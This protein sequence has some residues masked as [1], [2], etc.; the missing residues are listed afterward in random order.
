MK[1]TAFLLLVILVFVCLSFSPYRPSRAQHPSGEGGRQDAS[2]SQQTARLKQV[3]QVIKDLKSA[4]AVFER[5]DLFQ[6]LSKGLEDRPQIGAILEKGVVF[7]LDEFVV[8]RALSQPDEHMTLLLPDGLGGAI[9]LELTRADIFAPG[10]S[11]KTSQPT[12]EDLSDSAGIHYRGIVKGKERSLAAISVFKN[13]VMGFYS[14]ETEG[15]SVVGRFGGDNPNNEHVSYAVRDLK[16]NP[17]FVCDTKDPEQTLPVSLLQESEA[18]ANA[19]VRMYL[20][21]NFDLFQNKGSVANTASYLTGLFN[22]AATI[23]VNDGIPVSISEIFVWNSASPYSGSSTNV[24]TQFRTTRTSFNGDLAHLITLSQNFG[25]IAYVNVLCNQSFAYAVSD[26][27]PSFSNLPTYSWSVNVFTHEA[28]HNLGSSHTHACVW[29]GN[30]TAIDSCG[31]SAGVPYE[32]SCSGAP[33]PSTNGGTIMSYCH[34]NVGVNLAL[35]FGTQPRNLIVNRFNA[36]SCLVAC[37]GGGCTSTPITVGQTLNGSLTTAD[38]RYPTGSNWYSDAY[39]FNGVAGQQIAVMMSSSTFDTWLALQAPNGAELTFNNDSGGGT[40]S[41]IPTTSGFYTLPSTGTYKIQASS[42][43]QNATG[44]YSVSLSAPGLADYDAL[45]KAPKCGVIGNVCDSGSLLNS[46][47][48]IL[49]IQEPNQPNTI[50]NSCADGTSGTYHVDESVDAIKVSTLDGSNFAPGKTVKVEVTAWIWSATSDVLD[51]YF[52]SNANSPNWVYLTTLQAPATG[53][54]V[55]S[56]NYQLPTGASL[57]AV[58]AKLRFGGSNLSCATNSGFDDYD[59]LIFP[60]VSTT[61]K[62]RLDFDGDFRADIAVWRAAGGFWYIINSGNSSVT[63]RQWG[64]KNLGD[65]PLTGDFDGDGKADIA[66]WRASNGTWYII[67]SSNNSVRT[68]QWGANNLGDRPTPG[69]FDGDGRT[70]IAVWRASN[71]T[72]YIIN[73]SNNSVTVKQW[74][75]LAFGDRPVAAD[76]DGDGKADIAVWRASSGT[77]FIINSSNGSGTTRQWGAQ[78]QGDVPVHGDFDGDGRTD[79]AVW[80][81][82]NGTWYVINSSNGLQSQQQWGSQIFGDIPT[83]AD[84]DGDGRSDYAVWRASSGTWFIIRS[85]NASVIVQQWGSQ[86]LGDIPAPAFNR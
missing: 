86:S 74:G 28:G 79:I 82:V 20:E 1:K 10:F 9:E 23:F 66:V 19:C 83:P 5:R 41:R 69:D 56:A 21:A 27:D 71:G 11:I 44:N 77:W 57:Q 68:Q 46:R 17:E 50:N 31:P 12:I 76:Y 58:R 65:V 26:I 64:D 67:N 32:G 61:V 62:R 51:I 29:N 4:G 55:L 85:A 78:S 25:G 35:G 18:V 47:D 13:E 14:T 52:A 53:A 2:P 37:G 16:V 38:C 39:T 6:P 43:L 34:L 80:R 75:A 7:N 70:D 45:L 63:A 24:L 48:N 15:N 73:S 30:N 81:A 3:S 40:N 33:L 54:Q 59:D 42:N 22:Q 49:G 72:W 36:A 84:F 60:V 8:A